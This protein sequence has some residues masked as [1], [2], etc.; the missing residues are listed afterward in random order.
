MIPTEYEAKKLW[1][2]YRLP[3]EKRRHVKLVAE[4]ALYF[5]KKIKVNKKLLLAAALLHDI[6]KAVSSENHPDAAVRILRQEGYGG[7]ADLVKTHPLHAILDPAI[8]PKTWEEK[9][10]Y[11][12]DKMVKYDIVG[13]DKRFALWRDEHLTAQEQKILDASYP[14][15][16]ELEQE[17]F[18]LA[19]ISLNDIL[20]SK[21]VLL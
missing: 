5:A 7:V 12:A 16:K 21:E 20:K 14:K 15:V 4:V 13:V 17:V 1:E 9:L 19:R 11:L 10:L 2:K 18:K 6:D 8:A 3:E